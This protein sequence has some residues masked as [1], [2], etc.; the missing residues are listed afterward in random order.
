MAFGPLCVSRWV[1]G[2]AGAK[3]QGKSF[4]GLPLGIPEA[5]ACDG[6]AGGE[7]EGK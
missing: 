5:Q 4:C 1:V 6:E 3:G 7:Q 2:W